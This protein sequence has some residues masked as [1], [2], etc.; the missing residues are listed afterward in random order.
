MKITILGYTVEIYKT[1]Y[2]T[3]AKKLLVMS[4]GYG[5]TPNKITL[6]K[7]LR[8]YRDCSL[9]DAK[10]KVEELFDFSTGKPVIK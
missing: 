4:Y 3:L 5:D 10:D 7:A 9:S 2:N 1:D 8:F 6:I